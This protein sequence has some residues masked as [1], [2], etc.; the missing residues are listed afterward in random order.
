MPT[1][2]SAAAAARLARRQPLAL[3]TRRPIAIKR[4]VHELVIG[5]DA[6]RFAAALRR[7]LCAEGGGFG[8]IELRRDTG[9]AGRDFVLGERFHG[10]IRLARLLG[11]GDAAW[12]P[13]LFDSRLVVALEDAFLSDYAEVVELALT[14]APGEPYRV[15]YRY[16]GGTPMA[17][18]SE[19]LIEPIDWARCRFRCVFE[20]QELNAVGLSLLQRFGVKLHDAVTFVQAERA[21]ARAGAR[22]LASTIQPRYAPQGSGGG[23]MRVTVARP[24]ASTSRAGIGSGP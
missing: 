3:D 18:R 6:A 23:R 1:T 16:L 13:A 10:S 8:P 21:A 11:L 19:L 22:I 5:C 9:R 4:S 2:L 17:G 7:V 20:Y 15:A 12:A 14:P 24:I